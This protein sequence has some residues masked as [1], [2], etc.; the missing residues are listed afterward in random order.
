ME[1][2]DIFL[3][4][5]H[6]Y[7]FYT[8]FWFPL[9]QEFILNELLLGMWTWIYLS[10]LLY[11]C[12]PTYFHH[13]SKFFEANTE[14]PLWS[15]HFKTKRR[16]LK[17]RTWVTYDCYLS[18]ANMSLN[19]IPLK[20]NDVTFSAFIIYAASCLFFITVELMA[21][22]SLWF[23]HVC[24]STFPFEWSLPILRPLFKYWHYF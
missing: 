2:L 11:S 16:R 21:N 6:S 15:L 4:N 23:V 18:C 12:T 14:T 20:R 7:F 5:L 22:I 13:N 1:K 3:P 24:E 19:T 17:S 9:F 10:I 8:Y